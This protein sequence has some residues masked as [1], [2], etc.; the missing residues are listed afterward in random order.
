MRT[1]RRR[2]GSKLSRGP[3]ERTGPQAIAGTANSTVAREL[4][5]PGQRG[6]E[7]QMSTPLIGHPVLTSEVKRIPSTTLRCD[8]VSQ[9]RRGGDTSEPDDDDQLSVADSTSM[10]C[11]SGEN[12]PA[13]A[14]DDQDAGSSRAVDAEY[15]LVRRGAA[16]VIKLARPGLT[17]Q[18]HLN[19][20]KTD[21]C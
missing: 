6:Y 17:R 19:F 12:P 3:L 9:V 8:A 5:G 15:Q 4:R 1:S 11:A 16:T 2:S 14:K 7:R 13:M 21:G 20:L 10:A 18:L